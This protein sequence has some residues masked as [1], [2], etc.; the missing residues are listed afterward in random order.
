M[1]SPLFIGLMYFI[2]PSGKENPIRSPHKPK[3][4]YY[5]VL[6]FTDD[7]PLGRGYLMLRIAIFE[8]TDAVYNFVG[9]I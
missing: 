3:E 4:T 7:I 2:L 5:S 6:R 9:T 1:C 8:F